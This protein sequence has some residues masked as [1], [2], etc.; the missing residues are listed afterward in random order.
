[1]ALSRAEASLQEGKCLTQEEGQACSSSSP[2]PHQKNTDM[3]P[4]VAQPQVSGAEQEGG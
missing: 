4:G 1:V 2:T 3:V